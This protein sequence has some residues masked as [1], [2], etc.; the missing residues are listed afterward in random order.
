MEIKEPNRN[1]KIIIILVIMIIL[2]AL[3]IVLV[4]SRQ[5]PAVVNE[6]V[7][8]PEIPATTFVPS[9]NVPADKFREPVPANT[10]VPEMNTKLTPAE[11]EKIAIPNLVT[12]AAPGVS[13]NFRSFDVSANGGKFLPAEVIAHVGDI[14]HVNFTAV[15]KAYDV[16][17]PSY[18]MH[19]Q[20]KQGE[21]KVLEFQAV[22]EGSFTYFCDSCGGPTSATKGKIIIVK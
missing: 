7:I 8:I 15:D 6:P 20:I 1:K 9:S 2:T 14:V 10:K 3:V 13:S 5:Q 4:S 18:G 21:K 17:F 19:Q 16:V 22:A 12:S 11:K